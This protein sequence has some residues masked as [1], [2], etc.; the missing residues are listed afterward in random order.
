MKTYQEVAGR[1]GADNT[2]RFDAG[3]QATAF[4]LRD[5]Y[6]EDPTCKGTETRITLVD[7]NDPSRQIS[8][9]LDLMERTARWD[10]ALPAQDHVIAREFTRDHRAL[11]LVERHRQI[12][13]AWGL[14]EHKK[15]PAV[16]R[17]DRLYAFQDFDLHE[18][19][20]AIPF[21]SGGRRWA[22]IDQHCLNRACNC[23]DVILSFVEL[24]GDAEVQKESFSIRVSVD[25]GEVK[26]A[27]TGQPLSA[28]ERRAFADYQHEIGDW[29]ADLRLRRQLARKIG[30]RRLKL[31]ALA[32]VPA[33]PVKA[34]SSSTKAAAPLTAG[35]PSLRA[36][37]ND[38]CPCGSGRKFKKCCA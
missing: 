31:K 26:N 21:E 30:A 13:R 9:H 3:Q 4:L 7:Q 11:R 20:Y 35:G 15:A 17:E 32:Q 12:V 23:D 27:L 16:P 33:A 14:A 28:D 6:C 18:E 24:Q 38:P 25:D 2:L 8:L 34:G 19:S 22:A 36:G 29:Q 5:A 1:V 37:R 10:K